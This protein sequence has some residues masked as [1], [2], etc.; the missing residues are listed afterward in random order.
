VHSAIVSRY[1]SSPGI[2]VGPR[3]RWYALTSELP[4][5]FLAGPIWHGIHKHRHRFRQTIGFGQAVMTQ[6]GS[7]SRVL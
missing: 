7:D 1:D 5:T 3:R 4:A 2:E 6:E